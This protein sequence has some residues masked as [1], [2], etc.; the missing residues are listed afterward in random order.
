MTAAPHIATDISLTGIYMDRT[1]ILCRLLL[2]NKG[3]FSN[4]PLSCVFRL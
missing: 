2:Y 1:L 4:R 3:L